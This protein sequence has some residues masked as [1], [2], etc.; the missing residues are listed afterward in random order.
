MAFN[1]EIGAHIES[2]NGVY[3]SYTAC[4]IDNINAND[5]MTT[6]KS[7]LTTTM[8]FLMLMMI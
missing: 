8:T 4:S 3:Y 5:V 2:D 1:C 7:S 6:V